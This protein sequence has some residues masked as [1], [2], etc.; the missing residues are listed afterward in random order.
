MSGGRIS[1]VGGERWLLLLVRLLW[2]VG[3][4]EVFIS[5]GSFGNMCW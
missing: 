5:V 2:I 1:A 4:R 3:K